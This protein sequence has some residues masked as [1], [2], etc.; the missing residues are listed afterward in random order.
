MPSCLS[1]ISASNSIGRVL[2]FSTYRS[3]G[4]SWTWTSF[5]HYQPWSAAYSYT[6][7]RPRRT[8]S[9]NHASTKNLPGGSYSIDRSHLPRGCFG[10]SR[11]QSHSSR[12]YARYGSH[13]SPCSR[14][15]SPSNGCRRDEEWRTR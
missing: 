9:R 11:T 1:A 10:Y 7:Q 4:R 12:S 5:A 8:Y 14:R 3:Y 2:S 13:W 15:S 6:V